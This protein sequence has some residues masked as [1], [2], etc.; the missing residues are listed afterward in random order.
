MI[1]R[2]IPLCAAL[3]AL[4][5]AG[6]DREPKLPPEVRQTAT[7]KSIGAAKMVDEKGVTPL[8]ERIATIGLLNKRNNLT[9]DLIS[10][11]ASRSGSTT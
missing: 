6:C 11:P 4:A 8:A 7:A 10:S 9:S 5:L 2:P 3:L 1:P